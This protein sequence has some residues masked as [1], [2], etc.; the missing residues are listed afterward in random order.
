MTPFFQNR[1]SGKVGIAVLIENSLAAHRVVTGKNLSKTEWI[2]VK[3]MDKAM[4]K[5]T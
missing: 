1:E 5:M 3:C 2:A 4:V